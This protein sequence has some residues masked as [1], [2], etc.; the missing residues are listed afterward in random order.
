MDVNLNF[1]FTISFSLGESMSYLRSRYN[2]FVERN[3]GII[4]YNARTGAF[5]A[6]SNEVANALQGTGPLPLFS[7]VDTSEL[8][9]SGFI[10]TGNE[11]ELTL[12]RFEEGQGESTQSLTIA[13]TLACNFDCDYCYQNEYRTK[14]VM[15]QD[16]QAAVLRFVDRLFSIGRTN[17]NLCWYG[18]EPLLCKSIVY[19]MTR[20]IRTLVESRGGKLGR[21]Q[22]V[23]NGALLN[24]A[25]T[26]DLCDLG[27]DDVQIS[28]DSLV[29]VNGSKRG[30]ITSDGAPSPILRNVLDAQTRLNIRVRVNTSKANCGE[31]DEILQH[32]KKFGAPDNVYLARVE[33]FDGEAGFVTTTLGRRV[34]SSLPSLPI[35]QQSSIPLSRHEFSRVKNTLQKRV[36]KINH[37]LRALRPTPGSYCSATNGS[38]FAIDPDGNVSRCWNSVGSQTEKMGNVTDEIPSIEDS[39]VATLWRNFRLLS[40][41]SCLNC[42]VLPLCKG[43]CSYSRV[44]MNSKE[45]PCDS[46]KYS[47]RECVQDVC[48]AFDLS[49]DY[50]KSNS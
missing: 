13:P 49:Q 30:V 41:D 22:L 1:E 39:P 27:F 29:Y 23:T 7:E 34:P 11:I 16:V 45:P 12:K 10:H 36:E 4:G 42:S 24:H 3:D 44:F 50:A 9:V 37:H 25:S 20:D 33:D 43:G 46:I 26:Q 18:G 48:Q 8:L 6:L 14:N 5:D 40:Y 15:N 28:F 32:L 38:M 47:V 21:L 35:V 17:V 31:I 2:F 19:K